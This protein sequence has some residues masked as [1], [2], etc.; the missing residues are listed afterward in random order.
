MAV[1]VYAPSYRDFFCNNHVP[2]GCSCMFVEE[3]EEFIMDDD[4]KIVPCCE[5]DFELTGFDQ[6]L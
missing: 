1:W 2:R 3:I 5:Y 4:G 6:E